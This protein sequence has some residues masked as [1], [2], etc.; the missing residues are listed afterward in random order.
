MLLKGGSR[1]MFVCKG[2]FVISM[3]KRSQIFKNYGGKNTNFKDHRSFEHRNVD[4]CYKKIFL[5]ILHLI[6]DT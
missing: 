5:L 3:L 6:V 1:K 4:F 2:S